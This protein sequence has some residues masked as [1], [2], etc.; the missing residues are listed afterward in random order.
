L[1]KYYTNICILIS[2]TFLEATGMMLARTQGRKEKK[3]ICP[4]SS[5][6]FLQSDEHGQ[7][8]RV[9]AIYLA[10]STS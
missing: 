9:E 7:P 5:G 4:L 10:M 1:A 8:D 6:L 2:V 3:M